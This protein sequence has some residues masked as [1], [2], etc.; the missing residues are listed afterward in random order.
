MKSIAVVLVVALIMSVAYVPPAQ[1]APDEDE[2]SLITSILVLGALVWG[3]KYMID[4]GNERLE[5]QAEQARRE[6]EAAIQAYADANPD[7]DPRMIDAIRGGRIAMGMTA[8]QARLSF[9]EPTNINR[10]VGSW[11]VHEQWV[12]GGTGSRVYVYLEN[13]VV[14]SWQN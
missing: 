3:I 12:Y 10:S 9:G 2:P 5:E 6:R 1:A 4:K 11:G 14:T 7:V 8:E 13:G